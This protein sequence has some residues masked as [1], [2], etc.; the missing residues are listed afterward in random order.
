MGTYPG[1][2]FK[3]VDV[4]LVATMRMIWDQY[5]SW[6][7]SLTSILVTPARVTPGL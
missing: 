4:C 3:R 2:L 5:L 7:S 6:I 1:V